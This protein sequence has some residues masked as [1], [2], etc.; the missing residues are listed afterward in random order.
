MYRKLG[1]TIVLDFTTH[2]PTTGNVSDADSTPTCEVFEDANDTPILT[3]TVTKRT[4]KTGN[5]R[6]SIVATAGNNFGVGRS[7]NVI[8]SATVVL[9]TA[10]GRIASFSLDSK[11]LADLNDLAKADITFGKTTQI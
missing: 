4:G 7:Y 9:I 3:P 11:R 2:D 8:V 6:V 5:Y 1:D 10:K